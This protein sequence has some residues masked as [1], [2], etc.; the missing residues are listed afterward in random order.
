MKQKILSSRL[1]ICPA[2]ARLRAITLATASLALTTLISHAAGWG[3]YHKTLEPKIDL[4]ITLPLPSQEEMDRDCEARTTVGIGEEITLKILPEDLKDIDE[5]E[6]SIVTTTGRAQ[7]ELKVNT[8]KNG[9][10]GNAPQTIEIAGLQ[11]DDTSAPKAVIGGAVT[12][13]INVNA[14]EKDAKVT[15]KAKLKNTEENF[16]DFDVLMPIKWNV[17]HNTGPHGVFSVE[18]PEGDSDEPSY[19]FTV[20]DRKLLMVPVPSN[21][22]FEHVYQQEVDEGSPVNIVPEGIGNFF[23]NRFVHKAGDH[24]ENGP[25]LGDDEHPSVHPISYKKGPGSLPDHV[26]VCMASGSRYKGPNGHDC[27]YPD[28]EQFKMSLDLAGKHSFEW[29][30]GWKLYASNKLPL[31]GSF[32]QMES[33]V[34]KFTSDKTE[35]NGGGYYTEIKKWE[36]QSLK[37]EEITRPVVRQVSTPKGPYPDNL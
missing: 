37:Q 1:G 19:D 7:A 13:K 31:P 2:V 25:G 36:T 33:T 15:V 6:W 21:V 10:S 35:L 3:I 29:K 26:G 27:Y 16:I 24:P 5:T 9:N 8:Q 17:I 30:C 34:Q 4:Q 11:N 18:P 23:F 22:N 20:T 12:L 14:V 32:A 28:P